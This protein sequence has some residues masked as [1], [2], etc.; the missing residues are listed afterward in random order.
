[1]ALLKSKFKVPNPITTQ[2]FETI[3]FLFFSINRSNYESTVNTNGILFADTF[4][5]SG[6]GENQDITPS[7]TEAILDPDSFLVSYFKKLLQKI[8]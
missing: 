8:F 4:I 5:Q 1:M 3:Y 2:V 7:L 6:D